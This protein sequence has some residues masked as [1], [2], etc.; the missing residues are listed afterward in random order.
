MLF[1]EYYE[2]ANIEQRN[3]IDQVIPEVL[4]HDTRTN[5][6]CLNVHAIC[7]KTFT[8][9]LNLLNFRCIATA[10]SGIASTS[11]HRG[12]ILH[13]VFIVY[14]HFRKCCSKYY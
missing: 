10:V 4:Y 5:V 1:C 7:G 13:N 2:T 3:L 8:H 14:T 9:K 6:F 12:R 11:L